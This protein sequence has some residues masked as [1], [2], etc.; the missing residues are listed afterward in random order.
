MY[1]YVYLKEDIDVLIN[2]FGKLNVEDEFLFRFLSK[3][4]I[5]LKEIKISIVNIIVIFY[6]D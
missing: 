1:N 6:I 3:K 2:E 4:I 5:F